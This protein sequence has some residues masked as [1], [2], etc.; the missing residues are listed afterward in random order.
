MN[1]IHAKALL[2][3]AGAVSIVAMVFACSSAPSQPPIETTGTGTPSQGGNANPPAGSSS[4]S[5]GAID[6]GGVSTTSDASLDGGSCNSGSCATGCCNFLTNACES[7][8]SNTYCGISGEAC[9][10][11]PTGTSCTGGGCQ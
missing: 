8:Q 5:G 1:G 7:G 10:A 9:V 11:C 2:G 3:G 6:D 4:S